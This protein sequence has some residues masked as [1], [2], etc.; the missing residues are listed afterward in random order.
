MAMAADFP[1]SWTVTMN[2]LSAATCC[3]NISGN[4]NPMP[5]LSQD[6]QWLH[7]RGGKVEIKCTPRF[8]DIYSDICVAEDL[9]TL[10]SQVIQPKNNEA[11]STVITIRNASNNK[12]FLAEILSYD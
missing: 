1:F 5:P 7:Q 9:K 3:I 4:Y 6:I 12:T 11:A 2:N 8:V 10:K